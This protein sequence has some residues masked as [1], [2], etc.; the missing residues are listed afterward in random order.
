MLVIIGKHRIFQKE[1]IES[2][3]YLN[4]N[5]VC[6]Y[7]FLSDEI[8]KICKGSKNSRPIHSLLLDVLDIEEKDLQNLLN[9][10][11][12]NNEESNNM[13]NDKMSNMTMTTDKKINGENEKMKIMLK[14]V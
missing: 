2:C 10:K 8:A 3:E 6:K 13:F 11:R 7:I 12:G 1:M 9:K 5:L 4:V 14:R